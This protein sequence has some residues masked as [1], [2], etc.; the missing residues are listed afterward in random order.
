MGGEVIMTRNSP[1]STEFDLV[2]LVDLGGGG[3]EF[4]L[5]F[6]FINGYNHWKL[7][8]VIFVT[9]IVNNLILTVVLQVF[10]R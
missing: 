7:I 5:V 9:S 4:S 6:L 3:L 10:S 8:S 1:P 2:G